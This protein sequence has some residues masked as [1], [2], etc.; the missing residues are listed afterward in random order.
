MAE[1]TTMTM[2][3]TH[4]G[5]RDLDQVKGEVI[6]FS[7][8]PAPGVGSGRNMGPLDRVACGVGGAALLL[9]GL[10]RGTLPGF[11]LAALGGALIYQ[12]A[13]GYCPLYAEL[14]INTAGNSDADAEIVYRA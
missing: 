9:F 14:G 4:Q 13:S 12:G 6:P 3:R 1:M 7:G 5:V 11:A 2:P 10:T 8:G